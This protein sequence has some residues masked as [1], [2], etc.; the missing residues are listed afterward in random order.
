MLFA[1]NYKEKFPVNGW[2]VYD[3]VSEYKR[4]VEYATLVLDSLGAFSSYDI[5][6][7]PLVFSHHFPEGLVEC[8]EKGLKLRILRTHLSF[9]LLLP[10]S[11]PLLPPSFL[12]ACLAV[13]FLHVFSTL[14]SVFLLAIFPFF[15]P[16]LPSR[17]VHIVGKCSITK[18]S[19]SRCFYYISHKELMIRIQTAIK[20]YWRHY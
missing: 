5:S 20:F 9:L 4:Q 17:I 8:V 3:P 7:T 1:F 19:A 16:T 10:S 2:K 15:F 11:L 12:L 13:V 18:L 14:L 6:L